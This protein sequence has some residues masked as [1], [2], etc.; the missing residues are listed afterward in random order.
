MAADQSKPL[1]RRRGCPRVDGAWAIMLAT[2]IAAGTLSGLMGVGGGIVLTPVLHYLLGRPWPEAVALSLLVIA[3]QSPLGVH[4]HARKG[5]VSWRAALPLVVGGALGVAVGHWLLPRTPVPWLKLLFGLLMAGAAWRLVA[6]PPA[7]RTDD[8]PLVGAAAVGVGAGL[9]SRLL[10]VG[11]GIVTVPALTLLAVPVHVAVGTS[12]VPVFTN[13]GLA[14]GANLAGDL[15]WQ[16]GIVLAAG[17]LGGTL[18][19]VRA[20]HALPER[21]LRRVVAGG[22]AV[23]ATIIIA[24]AF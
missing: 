19:G 17:A 5:A 3:V 20:A 24:T 23:V 12:L 2:G 22:M 1:S 10:G 15:A 7:P 14:S 6:R 9:V 21:G 16:D 18:L 13:A 4:R 11:G 8:L